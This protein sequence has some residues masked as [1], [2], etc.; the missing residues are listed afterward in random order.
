MKGSLYCS[1]MRADF[2]SRL[3]IDVCMCGRD[4]GERYA[5]CTFVETDKFGGGSFMV[6][7][8]VCLR[9]RTELQVMAAG[10]LETICW[11]NWKQFYFNAG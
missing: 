8:G 9:G 10:T 5:E 4:G 1:H 3:V 2:T 11:C 6:W 7:G